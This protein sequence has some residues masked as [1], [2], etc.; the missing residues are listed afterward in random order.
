MKNQLGIRQQIEQASSAAQ[1]SL[2]VTEAFTY[3]NSSP[4]TARAIQRT[5][6]RRLRELATQSTKK[7]NVK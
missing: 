3:K 1:V 5:A 4:K 7:G 2:L 6:D